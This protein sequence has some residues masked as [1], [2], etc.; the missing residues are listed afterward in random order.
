[1]THKA[2]PDPLVHVGGG[3]VRG[4]Q[5]RGIRRFLGIPF[6][7]PPF[8]PRRFLNPE[9]ADAWDGVRDGTTF[10]PTPPQDPYFG[11][12]ARVL[13]SISIPGDDILTVNVWAPENAAGAPVM[14]WFYGGALERGA[15]ALPAYDGTAFARD[16][17]VFASVNYRVGAEGF[18]VLGGAPR[19]VGLSDAAAGLRWVHDEVA[20]FGGDPARITIA[21][22]SAGGSIVAGLLARPD[23]VGLV[24]GAIIESGPLQA[25][26]VA[27]AGAVTQVLAGMLHVPATLDGFRALTPRQLI[28][29]R[30]EQMTGRTILDGVPSYTL[31]VDPASLPRSPHE[32][33]ADVPVP[34][35]IGTNTDEY[36]LWFTPERLDATPPSA[37]EAV[38]AALHAP[39]G[40]LDAY[41]GTFPGAGAGVL[42]GQLITD[43]LMRE[44]AVRAADARPAPTFVYEFAWN[45]PVHDLHAGHAVELP[46]VFD[47]VAESDGK[48]IA[49][50]HAPQELADDIHGAWVRFVTSGDPGWAAFRPERVTRILDVP[51]GVEP[52]RRAA[53]LNALA[54]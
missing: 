3:T 23:T 51:G 7:R 50:A 31:C 6:A 54:G 2:S 14:V 30:R 22:E 38:A 16:G 46:F 19:N 26:P 35:L 43:R 48:A 53:V 1:M 17:V 4:V 40:A 5:S 52:L 44:P 45:S 37:L 28:D 27:Q 9:P 41:R 12:M 47:R 29:A 39:A 21:G 18:S 42:M 36:R 32:V 10:G 20:A 34:L 24:A 25:L 15:A 33:M 13:G 8:G 11:D 49:G